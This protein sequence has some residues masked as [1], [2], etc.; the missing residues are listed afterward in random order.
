MGG[1]VKFLDYT[2]LLDTLYLMSSYKQVLTKKFLD[3]WMVYIHNTD[4]ELS[5]LLFF[6]NWYLSYCM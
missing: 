5:S 4:S 3:I 2:V 1:K 6:F